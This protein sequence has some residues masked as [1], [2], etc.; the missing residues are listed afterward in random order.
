MTKFFEVTYLTNSIEQ[1]ELK[2]MDVAGYSSIKFNGARDIYGAG[3]HYQ[4]E[5]AFIAAES[6]PALRRNLRKVFGYAYDKFLY[7][8]IKLIRAR[9]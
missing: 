1:E 8:E 6:L 5:T 7:H 4:T 9:R 2:I 3:I